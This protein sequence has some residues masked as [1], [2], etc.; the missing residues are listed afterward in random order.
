VK[1]SLAQLSCTVLVWIGVCL[2]QNTAVHA[3]WTRKNPETSRMPSD[4]VLR[5]LTPPVPPAP[6]SSLSQHVGDLV[7]LSPHTGSGPRVD[8]LITSLKRSEAAIE[9]IVGQGRLLTTQAPIAKEGNVGVIAV[10]D[11]SVVDFEVLP[12]PRIIR[13]VGKRAGVTDFT[14]VTSDDET[15]IFE[16][17]VHYDLE[18]LNAQIRKAFPGALVRITQM[19]EHLILEGQAR[20]PRQVAMIEAMVLA[21]LE[22]SRAIPVPTAIASPNL[23]EGLA[24]LSRADG[25]QP[26]IISELG[27]ELLLASPE[28][29]GRP[30]VRSASIEPQLVN[31][32]T[33]PGVQQVLLQVRVAELNRT[34]LREIG[35]DTFFE[36]GPGNIL[37]TQLA[38]GQLS[39][40][41]QSPTR[42]TPGSNTTAFGIF[43][44]GRVE[45]MLRALRENSLLRVLAEPN[46]VA[47]TG[48]EASFLAGG[49]F[50]VPVPQG[51]AGLGQTT[52]QFKDFGVQL[53]FVPII[54]DDEVI[55]LEVRPEVSTIDESLGTTLVVGGDRVPGLN[56]RRVHTTVEMRE[57]ETLALAGLMQIALDANTA[58]IPG[59]GDL[60]YLGPFFSN[61]SH[62]R[63]E[64]ELLVLI[65]PFLISP[66]APHEVPLMPGDEIQD[67]NDLEF[68]LL[69]RIEGRTG[70]PFRSTTTW[71]DPLHF[72]E[73]LRLERDTFCGPVGF[74]Q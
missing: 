65:T 41:G 68:Y 6:T 73:L 71:D 7:E 57:G 62:K 45:I 33:V 54:L 8:D 50:P 42:L 29:A 55:R 70:V 59:L 47:L 11:P 20:S 21:F 3:Q 16:V 69:N 36:W 38:G 39:L 67:P 12:N 13:L 22:S 44:T 56:T 2:V 10:G 74:T 18:L 4:A 49:Q 34:G 32:M 66:M 37:G 64:K 35:A 23:E 24:D 60:P 58:R 43:P 19:R 28:L 9:L 48:H 53:N 5:P 26:P 15:L 17:R 40:T 1:N 25:N 61:T 63:V 46:L 51:G 14:L 30:A 31:L 27:L 72:V 52:V